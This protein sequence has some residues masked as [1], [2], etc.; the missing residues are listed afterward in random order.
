MRFEQDWG[1][2]DKPGCS[3][4]RVTSGRQLLLF[5]SIL[6]PVLFASGCAG[7]VSGKSTQTQPSPLTFSI[8]GTIAPVAGGSGATVS[9]GGAANLTTMANSSG[10]FTFTGLSNGAYTV[11]ASRAGYT[12][13]P[14]SQNATISGANVTGVNFAATA[15]TGQTFGISGAISPTAGGSGAT[16]T[17]SGAASTTTTANSSGSFTF[18]GLSNGTYAVTP[19]NTGYTFS[20]TSQS[21]TIN[22]ANVTGVNFTATAQQAHTVALT[23]NASTSTVAGYNVYRTT[24][25]GSF[26]VKINSTLNSSLAY[27]DATVSNGTTYYYVT[28]AIDSNG[29]ESL[30]SNEVSA[31]IP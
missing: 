2:M 26:Y 20:P 22:G 30:F 21:A 17:L 1:R 9:L 4:S 24:V 19:S 11:T 5:I 8:S 13:N 23:W 7:L 16:V 14:A 18:T 25:S 27:T 3:Q 28:T 12:F 29:I 31:A 6:L 15:Q 10:S